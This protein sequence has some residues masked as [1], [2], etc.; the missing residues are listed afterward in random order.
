MLNIE[1]SES[2]MLKTSEFSQEKSGVTLEEMKRKQCI[3]QG[4]NSHQ[5]D[6][7]ENLYCSSGVRRREMALEKIRKK[8]QNLLEIVWSTKNKNLLLNMLGEIKRKMT[9]FIQHLRRTDFESVVMNFY[10]QKSQ[11]YSEGLQE[12]F[13]GIE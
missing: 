3:M 1:I 9:L 4:P 6:S 2:E 7:K 12:R 8:N 10:K 13:L 5:N 11:K